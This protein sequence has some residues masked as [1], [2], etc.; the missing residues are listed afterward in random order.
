MMT[1]MDMN[2]NTLILDEIVLN[3]HKYRLEQ[4]GDNFYLPDTGETNDCIK[5]CT[6]ET[7]D[8]KDYGDLGIQVY[9]NTFAFQYHYHAEQ[10]ILNLVDISHCGLTKVSSVMT[11]MTCKNNCWT[12]TGSDKIYYLTNDSFWIYLNQIGSTGFFSKNPVRA[13][14][15]KS[16]EY[17]LHYEVKGIYQ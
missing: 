15:A 6:G 16:W 10:I 7:D 17:K 12:A 4:Y 5:E 13:H 1:V 9:G 11:W 8:W 14:Q 3:N 2:S